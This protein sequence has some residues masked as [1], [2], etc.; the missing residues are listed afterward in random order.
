MHIEHK[1]SSDGGSDTIAVKYGDKLFSMKLVRSMQNGSPHIDRGDIRF[2]GDPHP[3]SLAR[4]IAIGG[5]LSGLD[6]D[7]WQDILESKSAS[8]SNATFPVNSARLKVGMLDIMGRRLNDVQLDAKSDGGNWKTNIK[9]REINGDVTWLSQGS[10]H[11]M[12]KLDS[13]IFPEATPSKSNTPV[14]NAAP[15]DYPSISLVANQF[16]SKGKKLGK[17]ELHAVNAGNNW[18]LDSLRIENPD[19]VADMSGVW[20]NWRRNSSTRLR[21]DMDVTD[22]GKTLDR[23][24]Y[25]GTVKGSTATLKGNLSWPDGPQLFSPSGLSGDFSL[26]VG[27][28]QFLKLQPGVGRLLSVLSLQNL[29]R[30]LLLDFRDIFGS[31]FAF[32]KIA[33]DV[34]I[35][36]GVM[37][38]DNFVMEGAAAKVNISGETDLARETQYLHVKVTPAISDSVSLA[39][40]AGGPAVAVGAFIAQKIFK[41]PFN[42]LVSY[43]YDIVG[44]WDEPRELKEGQD[45]KPVPAVVPLGN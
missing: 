18:T 44:T 28:G 26:N 31:G 9:S 25:P 10:G 33:G 17:L 24:G 14:E 19:F 7:Q 35:N 5:T 27:K 43:E 16:E 30:R 4:G 37:R 41:D 29:P 34:R 6:V 20:S 32:D 40:L 3:A 38:S 39:A 12:A 45:K 15:H 42:Q 21:L 8:S 11:V 36:Q 13:L 2:G 22:L 23:F 1:L